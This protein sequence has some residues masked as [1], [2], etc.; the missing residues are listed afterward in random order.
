MAMAA[1][2]FNVSLCMP[3]LALREESSINTLL[4]ALEASG[5]TVHYV[6]NI[7]GDAASHIQLGITDERWKVQFIYWLCVG[8]SGVMA[9]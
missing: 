7:G 5:V 9:I 6:K 1:T 8:F 4:V 2:V 3:Q